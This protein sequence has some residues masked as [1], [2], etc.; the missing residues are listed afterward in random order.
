VNFQVKMAWENGQRFHHAPR[1]LRPIRDF[2]FDRTPF[3]QKVVGDTNPRE[4]NKQLALI[5]D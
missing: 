2:M 5:T 4:I 1:L 3:L